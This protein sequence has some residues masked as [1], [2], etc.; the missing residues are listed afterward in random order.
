MWTVAHTRARVA[1]L[2]ERAKA[3]RT[4]AEAPDPVVAVNG[5]LVFLGDLCRRLDPHER[6]PPVQQATLTLND[7]VI[8]LVVNGQLQFRN[9]GTVGEGA[10][11]FPGLARLA[12][13]TLSPPLVFDLT[14]A[15]GQVAL[16]QTEVDV[17]LEVDGARSSLLLN[18]ELA[19]PHLSVPQSSSTTELLSP[20]TMDET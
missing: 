11:L 16:L 7:T 13:P 1:A 14:H 8:P 19:H 12:L 15:L 2:I 5:V 20:N 9:P 6:Q 3:V 4:E 17:S 18:R 10:M